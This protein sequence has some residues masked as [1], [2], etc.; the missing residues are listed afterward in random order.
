MKQG[1]WRI[2]DLVAADGQEFRVNAARSGDAVEH[3][4][5][6]IHIDFRTGAISSDSKDG[7]T[8]EGSLTL[9]KNGPGS[10]NLNPANESN[11][12]L[13]GVPASELQVTA[14]LVGNMNLL[15]DTPPP[16]SVSAGNLEGK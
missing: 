4:K 2:G 7:T 12:T 8:W 10:M 1:N 3:V 14:A 9:P 15:K 11:Q 13:W 6:S 5:V 16:K